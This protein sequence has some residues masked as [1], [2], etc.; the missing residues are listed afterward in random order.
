MKTKVLIPNNFIF[1]R[2]YIIETLLNYFLGIEIT[3]EF[4]NEQD[5]EIRLENNKKIIIKDFFWSKLNSDSTYLDI[6]NIPNKI[7]FANY[8]FLSEKNMPII[9]G[10][11]FL[12]IKNDEII[13]GIDIFASSFYMLTL[14]EE[15]VIMQKD[16]FDR[17]PNEL[18]L[19][20]KQNF[21]HRPVVN[22][23]LE[24]LKKL[25]L[26]IGYNQPFKEYKYSII[27]TH[28]IDFFERY[29][30]PLKA[31]KIA[32]G[33]IIKRRN[34]RLFLK[35][36]K[37]YSL[38]K[39]KKANDPYDNFDYL[40]DVSEKNNV[41][42]EFYFIAGKRTDSKNTYEFLS[43]KVHKALKNIRNRGHIIGIHGSYYSYNN[44]QMLKNEIQRFKQ[45]GID[46]K[47]GRQH[48]LRHQN[49]LTWQI[50][51]Q[52]N[53]KFDSTIG[54]SYGS[55]FRAGVCFE[56]P[57]FDIKNK[58]KLNLTERPLIFMEN[59]SKN[60]LP[61]PIDFYENLKNL[62]NSTKK[63]NGQFVFL[64]H[65]SNFNTYLWQDYIQFYPEI[66]KF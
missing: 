16:K 9:Y 17:F 6:K 5:Y 11:D 40:M 31:L 24:L 19:S 37:E 57:V 20:Y 29:D 8:E 26:K 18:S 49:P 53:L 15:S 60:K 51:E 30:S 64:W 43:P 23:Y 54:F 4:Y 50:W 22:E 36:L 61:K 13:C 55:G 44:S 33:D 46:V 66:F 7:Q 39:F 42:S 10:N 2:K 3:I 41:K 48:F 27:P 38:K 63:Y 52:N 28:D 59:S 45:F 62:I 65:N 35:T 32:G 21:Y 12:Q 56:Y 58:K 1:E 25:L 47:G 34:F 14:W